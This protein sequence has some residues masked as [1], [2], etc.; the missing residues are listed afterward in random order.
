MRSDAEQSVAQLSPC[1]IL[2]VNYGDEAMIVSC[3]S[4]NGARF[5]VRQMW[6][7]ETVPLQGD[8]WALET[9]YLFLKSGPPRLKERLE[10]ES[11]APEKL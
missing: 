8:T 7:S 10:N 5:N 1:Q 6:D 4:R 9:G 11:L 2:A 3:Q